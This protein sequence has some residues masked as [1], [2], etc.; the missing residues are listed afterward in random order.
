[1][2]PRLAS[3]R[4]LEREDLGAGYH[5]LC[6]EA[7]DLARGAAGTFTLLSVRAQDDAALDPILPRPFSFLSRDPE[8]GRVEVLLKVVGRGTA[9]LAGLAPGARLRVLG[10]LGQG[11]P[12]ARAETLLLLA[13]GVGMPPIL[14]LASEEAGRRR[15]VVFYGGRGRRDLLL[16]ERF[17]ALGV[18][19]VAST[20]D[21][22]FGVRGTNV[23]ALRAW[24]AQA[25]GGRVEAFACAPRPMLRAAQALAAE[26]GLHLWLSLEAHMACGI[27]VCRGCAVRRADGAGYH[28]V[29]TDGPVL[30]AE[31]VAL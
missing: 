22:S 19:L 30:P 2:R 7:P 24:L 18:T 20:D 10:P 17:E 8:Q 29:C 23:G 9:A 31:A 4:L 3:V 14:D 27:G 26:V 28:M 25:S 11:F 13:G 16:L 6:L 12:E 15:V 21:G 1:M 5:R